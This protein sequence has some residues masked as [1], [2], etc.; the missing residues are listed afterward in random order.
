ME[1][2]TE[3]GIQDEALGYGIGSETVAGLVLGAGPDPNPERSQGQ[4]QGKSPE[5][6]SASSLGETPA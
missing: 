2:E 5:P 4:S 1:L 6:S 3:V